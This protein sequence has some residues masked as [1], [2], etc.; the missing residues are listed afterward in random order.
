MGTDAGGL[1]HPNWQ[2]NLAV[3]V[4]LQALL[5]RQYPGFCRPLQLR[6]ERFNQDLSAAGMILEVGAAGDS[7]EEALAAAGA[8]ARAIVTLAR[9]TEG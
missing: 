5:E 9:G 8:L 4:K 6:T 2:E 3:G 1:Y 7:L